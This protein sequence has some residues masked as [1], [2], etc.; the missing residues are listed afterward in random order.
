MC[1]CLGMVLVVELMVNVG[2][3]YVKIL[4]DNW[5][6]VIVDGKMCVYFEYI[7][8]II[9]MGYEILIVL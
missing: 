7:I 5:I 3:W 9:E 6:V 4:F 8:V 2:M 1:L